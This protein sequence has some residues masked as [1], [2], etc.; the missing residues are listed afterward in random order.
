MQKQMAYNKKNLNRPMNK[1]INPNIVDYMRDNQDLTDDEKEKLMGIIGTLSDEEMRQLI[2]EV[3]SPI[4]Y[5]LMVTP[6]EVD[7]IIEKLSDVIS[8]GINKAL[9]KN[10]QLM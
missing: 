8:G 1:L 6:K 5:N 10:V 4:G 9:H 2:Y 7:F 3:L